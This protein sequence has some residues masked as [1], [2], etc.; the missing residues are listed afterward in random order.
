VRSR[1]EHLVQA[2]SV[3]GDAAFD[4]LWASGLDETLEDV[5]RSVL[6]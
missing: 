6:D 4:E 5:V 2:R 1:D 3:L